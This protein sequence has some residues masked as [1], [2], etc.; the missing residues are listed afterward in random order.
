MRCDLDYTSD[1]VNTL[2]RCTDNFWCCSNGGNVTSCCNDPAVRLFEVPQMDGRAQIYN[3]SAFAP[4]FT[5]DRTSASDSSDTTAQDTTTNT[6]GDGNACPVTDGY[7]DSCP[8]S[9]S[10]SSEVT[11]VGVGVGVGIG[12][13][14]LAALGAA[15]FLLSKEKKRSRELERR[16]AAGMQPSW[17]AQRGQGGRRQQTFHEMPGGVGDDGIK[18]M[19]ESNTYREMPANSTT[20]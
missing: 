10:N 13:P 7:T 9:S 15:L 1:N 16:A 14:L 2:F 6:S 4:G 17:G 11:K 18:E 5:L 3:G 20:K 19:A 8:T 12:V